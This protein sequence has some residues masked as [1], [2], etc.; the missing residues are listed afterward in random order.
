MDPLSELNSKPSGTI[1]LEKEQNGHHGK[2]HKRDGIIGYSTAA[3]RAE[4]KG[5]AAV[6][7]LQGK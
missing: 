2:I 1:D 3:K 4:D 7:V 6:N 5:G